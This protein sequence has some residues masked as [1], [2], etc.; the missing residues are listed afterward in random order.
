MFNIIHNRQ[1]VETTL[2]STDREIGKMWHIH[3]IRLN[4]EEEGNSDTKYNTATLMTQ[5]YTRSTSCKRGNTV[6]SHSYKVL[7][8]IKFSRKWPDSHQG[9]GQP[10]LT[11]VQSLQRLLLSTTMHRALLNLTL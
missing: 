2:E 7:T 10:S 1:Q 8:V 5:C 9:L 3:T 4:F 6:L 11:A